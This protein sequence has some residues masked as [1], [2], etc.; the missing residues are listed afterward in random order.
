MIWQ[1][2]CKE[3]KRIHDFKDCPY[4]KEIKKREGDERTI[5]NF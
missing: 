5:K 1:K 4:C 3:C 2:K